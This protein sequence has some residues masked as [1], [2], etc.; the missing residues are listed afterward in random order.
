MSHPLVQVLDADRCTEHRFYTPCRSSRFSSRRTFRQQPSHLI[1]RR[2]T[3]QHR[4]NQLQALRRLN[5]F[6]TKSSTRPLC[7]IFQRCKSFKTGTFRQVGTNPSSTSAIHSLVS[8]LAIISTLLDW[9][10]NQILSN[11][12]PG[13]LPSHEC[14]EDPPTS[15]AV[16]HLLLSPS[17]Q[18]ELE[19]LQL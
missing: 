10:Q 6:A 3:W 18:Q 17:R 16:I 2:R 19:Q 5:L 11:L 15:M 9:L 1:S 8:T 13:S 4:Q 14:K 12:V 7:T